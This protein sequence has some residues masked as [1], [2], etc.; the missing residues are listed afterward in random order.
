MSLTKILK[1]YKLQ[2]DVYYLKKHIV[3]AMSMKQR[4]GIMVVLSRDVQPLQL[5]A[6]IRDTTT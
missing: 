3:T 1:P 2:L 4:H 5:R 6:D